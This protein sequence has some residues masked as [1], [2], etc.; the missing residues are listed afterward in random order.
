MELHRHVLRLPQKR[1]TNTDSRKGFFRRGV[2]VGC[3][4]TPGTSLMQVNPTHSR[5]F[6]PYEED[7]A[8][9]L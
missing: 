6:K 3:W 2:S 7:K 9:Y 5:I 4:L 8:C 1:H